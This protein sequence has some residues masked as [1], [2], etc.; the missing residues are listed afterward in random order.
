MILAATMLAMTL[1]SAT[2]APGA[3]VP[4]SMVAT[5]CAGKN[6]SPELRWNDLPRHAKSVA[7]I[8]HDPDAPRAGGF[9]H[10]VLYDIPA[11]ASHLDAGQQLSA[12]Q[13]GTN[14]T[15]TPGYYGPCP[16]PGNVHH[17]N[18]TLYA[19]DIVIRPRSALDAQGLLH[20]MRGHVLGK[21]TL[22]GLYER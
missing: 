13:T 17:Y 16:P 15:G 7:L 11:S 12:H 4:L 8:V 14:G 10:W 18:F 22:T 3:R 5:D 20:R 2:F 6:V 9:D 21:T 19:L 1:Q